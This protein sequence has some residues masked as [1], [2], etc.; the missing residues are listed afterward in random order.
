[1]IREK[2][3]F[4]FIVPKQAAQDKTDYTDDDRAQESVPEF[5]VWNNEPHVEALTN[6]ANQ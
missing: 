6:G 5:L 3:G 1:M 4:L 2:S